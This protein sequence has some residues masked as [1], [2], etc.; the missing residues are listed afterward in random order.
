MNDSHKLAYL[1]PTALEPS[2]VFWS[3]DAYVEMDLGQESALFLQEDE[4]LPQNF[5]RP[6]FKLNYPL[7]SRASLRLF[8]RPYFHLAED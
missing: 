7:Q 6:W 2:W 4:K 5:R 3:A 1:D 8:K